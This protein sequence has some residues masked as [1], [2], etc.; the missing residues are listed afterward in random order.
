[1]FFTLG[2]EHL[3]VNMFVLPT[4]IL[5]GAN[6]TLMEAM[7]WNIVPVAIGNMIGAFLLVSVPVWLGFGASVT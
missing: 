2:Y 6:V 5:L 7:M 4:G 3:V 1:M